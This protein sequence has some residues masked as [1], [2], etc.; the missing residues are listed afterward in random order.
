MALYKVISPYNDNEDEGDGE[1]D[2]EANNNSVT[3]A[4]LA[5]Y[6]FAQRLQYK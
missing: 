5:L 3:G 4:V 6:R 2:D 1:G